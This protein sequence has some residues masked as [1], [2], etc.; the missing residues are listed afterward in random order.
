MKDEND[1]L[2]ADNRQR[3]FQNWYYHFRCLWPSMSKLPKITI[4]LFL[5]NILRKKRVMMF[6]SACRQA[7]K[8]TKIESLQCLYNISKNKSEMKLVFCTQINIKTSYNL[9][10]TL[11]ASKSPR[12]DTIIIDKHDQAFSKNSSKKFAIFLQYMPKVPK[13]GSW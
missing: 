7:W 9:I 11:W 10:S 4:L 8:L 12:D 13:I 1:F 6:F 3:L 2:P 5:C